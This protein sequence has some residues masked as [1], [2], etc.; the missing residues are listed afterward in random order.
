MRALNHARVN[1]TVWFG[2]P[3]FTRDGSAP[4]WMLEAR[5][6]RT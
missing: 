6:G 1:C 5:R 4:T 2:L 3:V